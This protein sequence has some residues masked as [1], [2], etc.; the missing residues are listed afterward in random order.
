MSTSVVRTR[1]R[2]GVAA[3]AVVA[4]ATVGLVT[5][6]CGGSSGGGNSLKAQPAAGGGSAV[7]VMTRQGPMGTY[8]TD[9]KGR[10]LYTF[11]KDTGTTSNCSG[12]CAQYWP[13]LLTTGSAS[14]SGG[15]E[16]SKLGTTKR[17]DGKTQVTYGGHPVYLFVQDKKAG[18]T[19][20]QGLNLSGGVWWLESP[21]GANI[22]AKAGGG[23]SSDSGY[24]GGY[25]G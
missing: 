10:S 2:A 12:A 11:A 9:G 16:Q 17:S 23:S 1:F 8:L 3:K 20:G 4:L 7:T 18:D 6:A 21:A 19:N 13:P 15:A 14:A 5:A 22:T 24:G 25:G